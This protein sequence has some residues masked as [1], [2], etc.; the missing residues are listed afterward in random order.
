MTQ[1]I[2]CA[3]RWVPLREFYENDELIVLKRCRFCEES[4]RSP[5][6]EP[7]IVMARIEDV[8]A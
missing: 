4:W 8:R 6:P 5:A 2:I 7:R 3:H 1:E